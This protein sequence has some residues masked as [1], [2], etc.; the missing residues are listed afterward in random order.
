MAYTT[1]TTEKLL[2]YALMMLDKAKDEQATSSRKD[3]WLQDNITLDI[4]RARVEEIS[5]PVRRAK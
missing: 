4:I 5:L 3:K 1:Y 2:C